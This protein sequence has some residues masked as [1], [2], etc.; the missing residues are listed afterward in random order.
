MVMPNLPVQRFDPASFSR[1]KGQIIGD[2]IMSIGNN[3]GNAIIKTNSPEYKLAQEKLKKFQ[4][5]KTSVEEMKSIVEDEM[6]KSQL[7]G[8]RTSPKL[9][10]SWNA[11]SDEQKKIEEQKFRSTLKDQLKLVTDKDDIKQITA[12]WAK[13]NMH[14]ER[15]KQ[16]HGMSAKQ[17]R[18]LSVRELANDEVIQTYLDGL[19]SFEKT[20][21]DGYFND[22]YKKFQQARLQG[23]K[24]YDNTLN[25]LNQWLLNEDGVSAVG[26]RG[27]I[28][29]E[30]IME[31][32]QSKSWNDKG[33]AV[34]A[35]TGK[36]VQAQ[37]DALELAKAKKTNTKGKERQKRVDAM[38]EANQKEHA[39]TFQRWQDSRKKKPDLIKP[40]G[41]V[42]KLTPEEEAINKE[43]IEDKKTV[44]LEMS[45]L[46]KIL[47][48]NPKIDLNKARGLA[49]IAT[50]EDWIKL[51]EQ[52]DK[53]DLRLA[54]RR[55]HFKVPA[56][57][58]LIKQVKGNVPAEDMEEGVENFDIKGE[59]TNN[60]PF[61]LSIIP[62]DKMAQ[63]ISQLDL[64]A[65]IV[66]SRR[67][68]LSKPK[69]LREFIEEQ[70][71]KKQGQ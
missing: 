3:L 15:F 27:E 18:S 67:P 1:Q 16:K 25:G 34:F 29:G 19:D 8:M 52:E 23:D 36:E 60:S 9:A 35:Q 56:E 54:L 5:E 51:N 45:N 4:D 68:E 57:T 12:N 22:V 40:S 2:T 32:V 26:E 10:E 33:K 13:M 53:K 62:Q 44:E 37:R 30:R 58:D 38:L 41:L 70:R 47:E 28:T 48:F 64:D 66:D 21:Q 17:L 20:D 42:D 69:T 61:D 63:N 65:Y 43:T 71:Q 24:K 59:G 14:N 50:D 6:W 7:D 31:M 11:M 55:A 46:M 49:K 39:K